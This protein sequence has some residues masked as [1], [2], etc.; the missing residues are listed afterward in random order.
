MEKP[1]S[2]WELQPPSQRRLLVSVAVAILAA[3]LILVTIVLPAEYGVDPTGIGRAL[4]LTA[5]NEPTRTLRIVDVI[6]GNERVREMRIPDPGEPVPLPNPAVYQ[7]ESRPPQTRT[8]QIRLDLDQETE[9]KAVLREGK[10]LVYSWETDGGEVYVDF[11]GHDP[12]AGENFWVRYEELQSGTSSH[13][14][15]V[16]P[17]SG[18][19]GWFWLNV[20]DAPVVLTLTVTGYFDDIKDYGI[21]R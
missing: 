12:A 1:S 7:D 19:H 6:G 18:E 5:L 13:G 11:H 21:L 15:L 4:G 17:F 20:S 14:S 10:V 2:P 3:A 9:V 16:A 8:M